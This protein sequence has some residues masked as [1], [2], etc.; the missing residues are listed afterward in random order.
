MRYLVATDSVHMT[1]AACDYLEDRLD[2]EDV[3][4]VATVPDG[5][6]RD[7]DDAL[8]VANARLAGRAEV[9]TRRLETEGDTSAA[10]VAAART[11]TGR[12]RSSSGVTPASRGPGPRWARRHGG[13][14]RRPTDRSSCSRCRSNVRMAGELM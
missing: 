1:A 11:T 10:I 14:S 13:S 2:G 8:N 6:S 4:L 9:E 5:G 12:T 7:G 3:M